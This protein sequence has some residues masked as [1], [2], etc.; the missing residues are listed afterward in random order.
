MTSLVPVDPSSAVAVTSYL[1]QA[2]TWLATAVEQTGPGQIARAKA[3][4]ATAAEAAK[5]LGLTREIQEDAVEM[6]RRAEFAVGKSI[7]KGQDDGTILRQGEVR[8]AGFGEDRSQTRNFDKARPTDFA[9]GHEL[10]G[11]HG[12]GGIYS[13]VDGVDTDTFESALTAARDEGNL[14]RANVVRKV[15]QKSDQVVTRDMRADMI[16]SLAEQGHTSRQM[17]EKVG[18]AEGTIREIARDFDIEIPADRV[19]NKSRRLDHTQMVERTV[20]ALE[21]EVSALQYID[22]AEV[23]FSEADEWVA[24]L[25]KS[26]SKLRKFA[27]RIKETTHV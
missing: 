13:M 25:S 20:V 9:K 19:T 27:N 5:Q 15:M 6:L 8:T 11:V 14:S 1:E 10:T 22:F 17:V 23:D 21:N 26:I 16:S 7:R 24:S 18:V 2:K 12:A 4:I 3:E